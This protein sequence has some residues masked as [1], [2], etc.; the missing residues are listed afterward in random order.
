VNEGDKSY[1]VRRDCKW[2]GVLGIL[3]TRSVFL[4]IT[5]KDFIDFF[6]KTW[7]VC[8]SVWSIYYTRNYKVG[9]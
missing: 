8:L 3:L 4:D 2:Y 9:I 1:P 7:F 5:L 6:L